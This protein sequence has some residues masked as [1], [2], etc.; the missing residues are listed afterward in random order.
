M[1]IVLIW[2]RKFFFLEK[3]RQLYNLPPA[4]PNR[5]VF[6]YP[7]SSPHLSYLELHIY[8]HSM[9]LKFTASNLSRIRKPTSTAKSPLSPLKKQRKD[10]PLKKTPP[11]QRL[12]ALEHNVSLNLPLGEIDSLLKGIN[13][14]LENQWA[15]STMLH[16]RYFS[17]DAK[18]SCLSTNDLLFLLRG[19]SM[20][21]KAEILKYRAQQL[22]RGGVVTINQLYSLFDSRGNTFVDQSLEMY[23]RKGELRK[24]VISNALPVILRNATPHSISNLGQKVTYGYENTEVVSRTR[25]FMDHIDFDSNEAC[26]DPEKKSRYEALAKFKIHIESHPSSLSVTNEMFSSGEL[27]ILVE[28]GYLTLTSNHHNEIDVHQYSIACP[29]CGT[30]LKMINSG[31][32]WLVQLLTKASFKEML[33]DAI[34]ERWEGKKMNNFRRPF[35]GYELNWIL[36]DAKGSGV[37][38]AFKTPM[39]MAWRLTG[40]L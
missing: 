26:G 1:G 31:K 38:E 14:V 10:G 33:Q 4:F 17:R 18:L 15:E 6:S 23:V 7:R 39:G 8:T 36:A 32:V 28:A 22:P 37:V 34:F 11:K 27:K 12:E 35:Y 25:D 13:T 40:K 20:E 5:K 21:N 29:R 9:S 2:I 3:S 19:I 16:E 24:F 30:F